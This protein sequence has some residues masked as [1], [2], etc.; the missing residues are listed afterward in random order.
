MAAAAVV[1]FRAAKSCSTGDAEG[2]EAHAN[3]VGPEKQSEVPV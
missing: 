2:Q 1:E 3:H